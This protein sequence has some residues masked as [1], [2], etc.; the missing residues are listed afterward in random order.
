M[1][2]LRTRRAVTLLSHL[3]VAVVAGVIGAWISIMLRDG[4]KSPQIRVNVD[5]G[6]SQVHYG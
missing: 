2:S 6:A 3:A 5:G 1:S 4:L